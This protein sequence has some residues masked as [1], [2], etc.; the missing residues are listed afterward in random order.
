M[1]PEDFGRVVGYSGVIEGAVEH[2][3]GDVGVGGPGEGEESEHADGG[4]DGDEEGEDEGGGGVV[5]D[6]ADEWDGE[7]A[8]EGEGD[9]EDVVDQFREPVAV[10]EV[11]VLG[12]DRGDEVVDACHL[13]YGEDGDEDEPGGLNLL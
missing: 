13:D 9:V 2:E 5:E 3:K 12:A 1:E 7:D 10:Q 11:G 4:G 6:E 8:A